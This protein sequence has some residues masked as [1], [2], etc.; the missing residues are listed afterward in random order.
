MLDRPDTTAQRTAT[1]AVDYARVRRATVELARPLTAED[2]ALQ[3]MPLASPVKWHLGHTTWFFEEFVLRAGLGDRFV[4]HDQRYRTLF[5]SYYDQVGEAWPRD[6]R[7]VLSRPSLDDVHAYRARVD[8]AVIGLLHGGAAADR[9]AS[10][11]ELGLHHEQQHQEL[12]LTDLQHLFS[13]N[14]CLPA[15]RSRP[16]AVR[17]RAGSPLPLAMI[18]RAGG[19]ATIGATQ[20]GFAF[21]CE[22]PRHRVWLEPYAIGSRLVTNGEYREFIRDG[23]YERSKLWKSDGWALRTAQRWRA[24]LYWSADDPGLRFTLGGLQP[25]DPE[26]PVVHVSWYEADAYARWAGA[27]LPT[28]AEWEA[29]ARD[30]DSQPGTGDA[31]DGSWTPPAARS[32]STGLQQMFGAAWQWTSSA[33]SPYPGFRP[34][35]GALGEYNGKFMAGQY[36]LRGGSCVTPG[37]HVRASYRNFFAPDAR[38]QFTGIRIAKDRS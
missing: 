32:D 16:V 18:G 5:N 9:L 19:L 14:P 36:V 26:A 17:A 30:A 34:L 12:M 2:A 29:A 4:A 38:W 1:L 21:D 3:S 23:G 35:A 11:V 8:D 13:L 7:G 25:L 20:D 24:P 15:Y 28:E 37:G 33:F 31:G 10:V 6:L 22:R 27:R